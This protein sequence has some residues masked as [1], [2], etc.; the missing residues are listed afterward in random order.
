M[1]LVKSSI[2]VKVVAM[3]LVKSSNVVKELPCC[4]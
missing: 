1:Q 3:Q 4:W 2:V